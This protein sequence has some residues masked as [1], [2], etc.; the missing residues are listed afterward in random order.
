MMVAEGI[1]AES[2][3]LSAENLTLHLCISGSTLISLEGK[4]LMGSAISKCMQQSKAG[5]DWPK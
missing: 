4:S 5:L 1:E 3:D 2:P